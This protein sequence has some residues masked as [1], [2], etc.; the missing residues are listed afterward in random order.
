MIPHIPLEDFV[1]L[2]DVLKYQ[3]EFLHIFLIINYLNLY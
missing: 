3:T 1:V 2:F